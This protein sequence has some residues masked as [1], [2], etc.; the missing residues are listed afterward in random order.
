MNKKELS[1][2]LEDNKNKFIFYGYHGGMGGEFICNY[3]S[4]K[5]DLYLQ[6]DNSKYWEKH[7]R[8]SGRPPIPSVNRYANIDPLFNGYFMSQFRND[9]NYNGDTTFDRF[10]E[11]IILYHDEIEVELSRE[12]LMEFSS[13]DKI[14]IVHFHNI[15][16]EM[17]LFDRKVI[18]TVAPN[19]DRYCSVLHIVK[20]KLFTV[21][22]RIPSHNYDD[23]TTELLEDVL[24]KR[25]DENDYTIEEC[26]EFIKP[27][28][29]VLYTF[30]DL[31]SGEWIETEFGLNASEFREE[32]LKWD[33]RNMALLEELKIHKN[34]RPDISL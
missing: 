13:S 32:F 16:E 9:M 31:F 19:W 22:D 4:N 26:Y 25:P 10:A 23:I 29:C 3:I 11:N 24:K 15:A 5:L 30:E 21:V 27:W 7:D 1:L 14:Y 12:I 17:S 2:W 34:Y 8:I 33:N 28:N 6:D 18:F 20:N